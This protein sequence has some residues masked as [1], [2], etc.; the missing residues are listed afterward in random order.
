MWVNI[1][2]IFDNESNLFFKAYLVSINIIYIVHYNVSI[3]ID[4]GGGLAGSSRTCILYI[5]YRYKFSNVITFV[6]R[7]F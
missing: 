3:K 1:L 5:L 6:T 7:Y 2:N 4:W